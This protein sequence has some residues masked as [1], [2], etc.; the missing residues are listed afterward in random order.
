VQVTATIVRQ[1]GIHFSPQECWNLDNV[2]CSSVQHILLI[3]VDNYSGFSI[4]RTPMYQYIASTVRINEQP[5]LLFLKIYVFTIQT[6]YIHCVMIV[7]KVRIKRKIQND[8][9]AVELPVTGIYL[10]M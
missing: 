10:Y 7:Y 8:E 4:I 5:F 3:H 6:R 1:R 2:Y 9:D